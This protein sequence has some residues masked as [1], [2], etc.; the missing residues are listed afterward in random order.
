MFN[1]DK[2]KKKYNANC[3][4][5]ILFWFVDIPA[6]VI[7][8]SSVTL[9]NTLICPR[10]FRTPSKAKITASLNSRIVF[11]GIMILSK[12]NEIVFAR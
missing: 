6:T 10:N 9:D 5:E 7:C 8:F 4:F 1:F 11:S 2:Y 3:V 12:V